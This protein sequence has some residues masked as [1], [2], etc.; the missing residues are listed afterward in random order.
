MFI[1]VLESYSRYK[2]DLNFQWRFL[3]FILGV[4]NVY[5]MYYIR[6]P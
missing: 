1:N 5:V 2:M 6:I 4:K 3:V